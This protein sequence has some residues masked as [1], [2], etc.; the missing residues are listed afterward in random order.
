[1]HELL[2]FVQHELSFLE[3]IVDKKSREEIV[4]KYQLLYF[5]KINELFGQ[6]SA[7][8]STDSPLY[9]E[10]KVFIR[11]KLYAL[12][13]DPATKL[14][15][16]IGSKPFGYAGDFLV[17]NYFY[18][19]G[20]TGDTLYAMFMDRYTMELPL[21][22]AHKNRREYLKNIIIHEANTK[23][24]MLRVSSFACGPAPEVFDVL[25]IIKDIHFNL[26]DGEKEAIS[27]IRNLMIKRKVLLDQVSLTEVNIINLLRKQSVFVEGE[28]DLVY[29]AGFIDYV[30]SATI[31]K[32][33]KYFLSILRPGGRLVLVNVSEHDASDV[34][35]KM[36]GDWPLFH[37]TLDDMKSF[38][39]GLESVKDEE[40]WSDQETMRNHYLSLRKK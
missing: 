22:R 13:A 18:Q 17:S 21:A 2:K 30:Q 16:Q 33:V 11:E 29:C 6:L 26:Y 15:L 39:V 23:D 28:Q 40:L 3:H 1:M 38:F 24:R 9:L 10:H 34:Y 35:L 8:V 31:R 7:L 20:Y 25:S 27:L 37:R 5:S 36:L 4:K 14:N 12:M 32:L 19:D